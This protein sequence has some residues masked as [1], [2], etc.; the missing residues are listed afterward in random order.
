MIRP[1][2]PVFTTTPGP[3]SPQETYVLI[4]S[5]SYQWGFSFLQ[6]FIAFLYLIVWSVGIYY[7]SA[8]SRL[9]LEQT[10]R[11]EVP[12]KFK[13]TLALAQTMRREL[14]ECGEDP[15]KLTA[16]QLDH[17]VRQVLR[18]GCMDVPAAAAGP[19]PVTLGGRLRLEKWWMAA[20]V[21]L[22]LFLVVAWRVKGWVVYLDVLYWMALCWTIGL[23][24][25]MTIGRTTRSRLFMVFC[26]VVLSLVVYAVGT[27]SPTS[28][29][30]YY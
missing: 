7:I 23:H 26:G 10:G 16:S 11:A 12:T 1:L 6:V 8:L 25:A 28:S 14:S 15:A 17:R 13:A 3:F 27:V 5:Q 29:R 24:V 19:V 9:R 22:T 21:I 30:R 18:G 4:R 2:V 20:M